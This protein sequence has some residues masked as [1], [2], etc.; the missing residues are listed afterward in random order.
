[1]ALRFV[2]NPRMLLIVAAVIA[3]IW[4]GPRII[5]YFKR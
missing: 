5:R 3:V 1:L 2:R 4:L